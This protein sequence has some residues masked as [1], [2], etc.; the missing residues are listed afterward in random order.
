MSRILC[1]S[2]ENI[3]QKE[4]NFHLRP[5]IKCTFHYNDFYETPN[6]RMAGVGYVLYRIS[7][8]SVNKYR[9]I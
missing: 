6:Y 1:K 3:E 7:P 2:G 4:Y 9:F 8:K 5:Y